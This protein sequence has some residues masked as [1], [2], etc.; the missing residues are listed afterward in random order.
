MHGIELRIEMD[1]EVGWVYSDE[2]RLKQVLLNLVTNAVKFTGDDGSVV[3]RA[4]R[5][6]ADIL[7]TVTD[8]GIGVPEADRE[9]IFESFQQGGRGSS[10]EEGTGLG[11]TLSR[12]IVELLGGRMWLETEVGVGSTFGFSLP[13]RERDGDARSDDGASTSTSGEVVIIEDDRPSLDLFSAYLSGAALKVTTAR[14]GPSGLD[15]V[16]RTHP[17]A[18]L[19]DIRLPGIDGWTVLK[20]LKSDPTTRDIGNRRVDRRREVAWCRPG[21]RSVPRQAGRPRGVADCTDVNRRSCTGT[22]ERSRT[23]GDAMTQGRV[24]VVEDNPKN[25][26]LV[27]DVLTYSGYEVIEATSGEDGV[28]LAHEMS[29]DL[30]LMDLQ[31]PGIDGAEALRQIRRSGSDVPVVAVTAFAMDNDRARAP[32]P[33]LSQARM[34]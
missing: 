17:E 30:I 21:R 28:R 27:R 19:L 3:V 10:R 20:E 1:D 34:P 12:R 25:L 2:L 33:A 7:I 13:A 23:H 9:R 24:L 16:R 31:L 4:V 14:D 6:G 18:V 8:T 29:P 11:L 32:S 5:E 26:K 22:R 15:A